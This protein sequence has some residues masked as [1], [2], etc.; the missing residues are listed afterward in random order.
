MLASVASLVLSL[1]SSA[2]PADFDAT[3]TGKTLR[4]DY[5]HSGTA[6]EEF[7]SLDQVRLEGDW[8]GSR[9]HLLDDTNLGKYLFVIVDP[10]T[11]Q[12]LYSRGF[13][14]IFGEWETTGEAKKIWRTYQES[15]RF[16]EPKK[17][18]QVVLKKRA[19]DGS[20]REIYSALVDPLGRFV[21]RSAITPR[22]QG[23]ALFESGPP[24]TKVDLLVLGEGYTTTEGNKFKSDVSRLVGVMFDTEPYKS[25]R[26]DF[27]VRAIQVPSAQSGISNPR[28]GVWRDSPLGLSFNAF[29]SDRYVLTYANSAIREIAAQLPYD[30]LIIVFNDRKYGG[31]GIFNLY[32]TCAS[33]TE[34]SAYVFVHEFGHSFAGLADEYYTSQVSYETLAPEGSEPW[35]PNITA[36]TDPKNVKWRDLVAPSTPIPTPWNQASFDRASLEYQDKRQKMLAEE[37]SEDAMEALFREVKEVTTPMLQSEKYFGKVGAFEGAA[38]QAKGLY[39]PEADCIMFTRN[40]TTFCK[41]C[42]RAI[43]RVIRLYAE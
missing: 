16:P 1:A 35:E 38:Y 33:D 29:D 10:A 41:V 20:F 14:S 8:P 27:N 43:E 12:P 3:F 13:A 23:F 4:F 9:T 7:V 19:A 39:R 17:S 5:Y 32:A 30:A 36:L 42:S 21:N 24:P 34:P 31:G 11:N 37:A 22:G 28:K 2:A 6:A 15:L 40:P 25:H 26:N 18:F